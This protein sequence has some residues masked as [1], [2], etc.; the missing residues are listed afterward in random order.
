MF[1]IVLKRD[2]NFFD[3]CIGGAIR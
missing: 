1:S 3:L 2:S